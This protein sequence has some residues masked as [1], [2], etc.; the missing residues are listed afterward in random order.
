[1][2]PGELSDVTDIATRKASMTGPDREPHKYHL[3]VKSDRPS[4]GGFPHLPQVITVDPW[5]KIAVVPFD[6][7][8]PV[9]DT[10]PPAELVVGERILVSFGAIAQQE[11][12]LMNV[13]VEYKAASV[14]DRLLDEN[15]DF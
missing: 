13:E 3:W 6:K 9:C 11:V 4:P 1:M 7:R 5:K 10:K 8:T 12:T 14:W 2:R 15:D